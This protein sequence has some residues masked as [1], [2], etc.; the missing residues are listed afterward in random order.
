MSKNF[1]IN[2]SGND[3]TLDIDVDVQDAAWE[4]GIDDLSKMIVQVSRAVLDKVGLTKYTNH[5]EFSINLT[6]ND[7]IQ[8]F[9]SQYRGKNHPTNTLSF[10]A[11]DIVA[12]ELEK[13]NFNDG[14]VLLGDIIFARKVIEDEAQ[15][16][17]KNFENHFAHLLIHGILHLLGH[18]HQ[19][20]KEAMEM[21]NLEVEILSAFNIKSPYEVTT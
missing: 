12:K 20:E 11:Q 1:T 15:T 16:Q 9:N 18:D 5:I 14:F 2:D 10:P 13:F 21:E 6:N 7:S 3:Y 17:G 19:S 4:N 8:T